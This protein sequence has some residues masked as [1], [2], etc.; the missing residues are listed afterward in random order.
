MVWLRYLCHM[1]LIDNR[2]NNNPYINAAIEEYMVRD[3]NPSKEDYL[4]LYINT[5]CVVVGRNQSI[6]K[7]VNFD[8]LREGKIL[9][10]R[11]SGGGTVY[12]DAGNLC[13]AF[14]IA[15]DEKK[16]NN[17]RHIN[18]PI[19]DVLLEAGI[20]VEFNK[21][22]DLLLDEKKVSGNAQFTDRKNIL[23]HGTVLVNADMKALST[24]LRKND[25]D[26][27]SRAISSVRSPVMN[28]S[29]KSN[30]FKTADS[31]KAHLSKELSFTGTYSFS[32]S[33]WAEINKI[34]AEKFRSEEWLWG[35]NPHTTIKK[36]GVTIEIENGK[37][38]GIDSDNEK[39]KS[40]S[41]LAYNYTSLRSAVSQE[42]LKIIF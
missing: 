30:A 6:Y 12:H 25:F 35:R 24:A 42:V 39:L 4:L 19:V 16:V 9:L 29:D 41:G 37:I 31:L 21:R 11:L 10:R 40:L 5:A 7:E 14:L 1:I 22:S 20:P 27:Q 17:Y 18:Q 34:A 26:V 13:F 38:A 2:G 3:M 36:E 32:D 8:Y 15:F 33:E 28:I 23:S